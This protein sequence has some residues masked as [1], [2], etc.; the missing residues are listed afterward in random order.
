MLGGQ[1]MG[2]T[3]T[4]GNAV[5]EFSKEYYPDLEARWVVQAA[6]SAQAPVFPN[7][8]LTRNTNERS[9]SYS[10]WSDFCRK[11]GLYEFFYEESGHLKAGHPGCV[12]ITKEDADFVTAALK[13]YQATATLPPGFEEAFP[14]KDEPPRY[15]YHLA[16]LIWLEWWMRWAVANCETPAIQNT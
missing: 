10:V 8:E 5:P 16:R 6:S 13:R 14:S 2:Y 9:P 15:D 3:F 7:D 4:V 11:T 12:G 1:I